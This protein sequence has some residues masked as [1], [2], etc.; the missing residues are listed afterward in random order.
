[1]EQHRFANLRKWLEQSRNELDTLF[2]AGQVPVVGWLGLAEKI[3]ASGE[4]KGKWEVELEENARKRERIQQ[5]IRSLQEEHE[6]LAKRDNYIHEEMQLMDEITILAS[7]SDL[8]GMLGKKEEKAVAKVAEKIKNEEF[9]GDLE[10]EDVST[11]FSMFKMDGLFSRFKKNEKNNNLEEL[12]SASVADLQSHL[13]LELPQAAE[14][15][16][17]LKLLENGEK[18]AERHLADCSICSSAPGRLLR[19]YG[20]L[21]DEGNQ[22]DE[23][24]KDWQGY[25]L[26]V[27]NAMGAA[28]ALDLQSAPL[29]S[30]FANCLMKIHKAHK[31]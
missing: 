11:L 6:K 3:K 14:M 30:K 8:I 20:M 27:M 4:S 21:E 18:G 5:Q 10:A 7:E 16:F 24:I 13:E 19:E 28:T 22:I 2:E 17:K 9:L 15:L 26:V 12:L 29:R 1:M 25:F 23:K 31:W